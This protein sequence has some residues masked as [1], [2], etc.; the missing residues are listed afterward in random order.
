MCVLI[1][2]VDHKLIT[3]KWLDRDK[4]ATTVAFTDRDLACAASH[5]RCPLPGR[6]YL[7]IADN[8]A[9]FRTTKVLAFTI[10]VKKVNPFGA[11][12]QDFISAITIPVKHFNSM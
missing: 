8:E 2:D 9:S 10:A 12:G 1:G 7:W 5:D 6:T 4:N 11:C 3:V